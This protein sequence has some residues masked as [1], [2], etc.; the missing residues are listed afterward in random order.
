MS[1][2]LEAIGKLRSLFNE[3]SDPERVPA[4]TAYMKGIFPFLGINAPRRKEL[5]K[6]WIKDVGLKNQP[7][8]AKEII[9]SLYSEKEREFHYAAIDILLTL[10]V[11]SLQESDDRLLEFM[12]TIHSWWDSVDLIASHT[13]GNYLKKFPEKTNSLITNWRNSSNMWLNRSCLLYQLKYRQKT[14]AEL[15]FSLIEQ[16]KYS[17]EFFIRKAIGWSLRE[18]SKWE[19]EKVRAFVIE[20]GID[21]L[22]KREASKYL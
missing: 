3:N 6:Q 13:L 16:Y 17:K 12:I 2:E 10:P 14:N 11:K 18:Y 15:L 7:E 22:A 20:S 4:M 5:V 1:S 9:R 21:G 19:K 8:K